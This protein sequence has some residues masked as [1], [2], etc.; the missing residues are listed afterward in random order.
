M[1]S[2]DASQVIFLYFEDVHLFSYL[3]RLNAY[4]TMLPDILSHPQ[5]QL[6]DS[7]SASS[8]AGIPAKGPGAL[9][10]DVPDQN[11]ELNT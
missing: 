4:Q 7:E 11:T 9:F 1:S 8:A 5:L 3:R 10:P 2:S 6:P